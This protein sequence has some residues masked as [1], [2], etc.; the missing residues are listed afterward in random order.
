MLARINLANL[1]LHCEHW[2][3]LII[4]KINLC[5]AATATTMEAT[6]TATATTDYGCIKFL[7]FMMQIMPIKIRC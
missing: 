4:R 2:T 1:R 5:A 3:G 7:I 6:T